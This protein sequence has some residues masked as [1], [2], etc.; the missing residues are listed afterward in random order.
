[1]T[2]DPRLTRRALVDVVLHVLEIVCLEPRWTPP[3]PSPQ[4][5]HAP[6]RARAATAHT[7]TPLECAHP[8]TVDPGL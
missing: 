7:A 4:R 5:P 1:M 6:R 3:V 8:N 2:A